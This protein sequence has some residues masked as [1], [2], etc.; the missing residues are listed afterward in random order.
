LSAS[1]FDVV[2]PSYRRPHLLERCLDALAGQTLAPGRI[3]LVL[4]AD[5]AG[6][7]AV[8]SAHPVGAVVVTVDRPG[9][10]AAMAA[11]IGRTTASWVAFTD[12]DA[13]PRR[14]WL[15]GLARLSC[16][17]D[18]GAVGG[19]DVIPGQE[20]PRRELVGRIDRLGRVVGNHH[21][22]IGPPRD[23]DVLKG[24][25]LAV[26]A[27][28]LALPRPGLLRGQGAEVHFELLTCGWVRRAG[29][30]L[31]YDPTVEVDHDVGVRH[32]R[33]ARG[34]RSWAATFDE[35]HNFVVASAALR[36]RLAVRRLL[37]SVAV[38]G[39]G[40]PGVARIAVALVARRRP[41]LGAVTAAIAGAVV[42]ATR[43]AVL[44]GDVVETASQLRQQG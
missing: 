39:S 40:T 3:V 8:A 33:D 29:L 20:T 16:S 44:R 1:Q 24:V 11:G 19:R 41:P 2:V 22:G 5:D 23:V 15:E 7:R 37:Y 27:D 38:G 21:L 18:V 13:A 28:V 36:R 35:A 9:V 4:R 43:V 30:R 6:G 31:V 25:S 42:G 34:R 14:S 12:D 32:D 26:R 10:I 17:A